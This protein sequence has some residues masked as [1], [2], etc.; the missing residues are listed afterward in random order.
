M[1]VSICFHMSCMRQGSLYA[2][3]LKM[4]EREESL[5]MVLWRD[6]NKKEKI[7]DVGLIVGFYAGSGAYRRCTPVS[8]IEI[9]TSYE[10]DR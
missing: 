6:K 5:L 10:V 9:H 1:Q 8:D 3:P 4:E 7:Q 2:L